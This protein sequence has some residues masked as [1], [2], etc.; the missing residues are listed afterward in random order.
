[1]TDH[2]SDKV[3]D[4]KAEHHMTQKHAPVTQENVDPDDLTRAIPQFVPVQVTP[5]AA[6]K[7]AQSAACYARDMME[8][9]TE[10]SDFQSKYL[11][12]CIFDA[13]QQM[14]LGQDVWNWQYRY[15]SAFARGEV[16][17]PRED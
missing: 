1:M 7:I 5:G 2:F 8:S 13:A 4:F 9:L 10:M 12:R 11:E 3:P 6:H 17:D 15:E 16:P 14:M